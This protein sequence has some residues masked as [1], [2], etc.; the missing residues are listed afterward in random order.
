[1][2]YHDKI[3]FNFKDIKIDVSYCYDHQIS[4]YNNNILHCKNA[5]CNSDCSSKG[6]CIA[7]IDNE[8]NDPNKN[9]CKC[10]EG[11]QGD[12]CEKKIIADF[13]IVDD[14]G[15]KQ[16]L[17]MSFGTI[18][19]FLSYLFITYMDFAGCVLNFLFK[20]IGISTILFLCYRNLVIN[21]RLG[22]RKRDE[23]K[24]KFLK[25]ELEQQQDEDV[26]AYPMN[27][28]SNYMKSTDL[29]NFQIKD[30]VLTLKSEVKSEN[31]SGWLYEMNDS[32]HKKIKIIIYSI[33]FIK[34][35]GNENENDNLIKNKNVHVFKCNLDDPDLFYN[36]IYFLITILILTI[37]RIASGFELI[38]NYVIYITYSSYIAIITGPIMN[39]FSSTAFE[40]QRY[41]RIIY[42]VTINSICYLSIFIILSWDKVYYIIKRAGNKPTN[43]FIYKR[44]EKCLIHNSI[45]CGC[46][47]NDYVRENLLQNIDVGINVYKKSSNLILK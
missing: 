45:S 44:H 19:Y 29:K 11:F 41:S 36:A 37:G 20:H 18:I 33:K 24:F 6:I 46:K 2:N 35:N 25:A 32:Y 23:S 15:F 17:H 27:N 30:S 26:Y 47:L 14:T 21:Y 1:E 34:S 39:L 7:G 10:N 28:C 22:Q 8:H 4:L 43:Y 12:I 5:I 9:I 3:N 42:E 13:R 38:Y 40:E 16:I 31:S